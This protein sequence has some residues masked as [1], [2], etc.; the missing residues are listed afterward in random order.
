MTKEMGKNKNL[1]IYHVPNHMGKI[2]AIASREMSKGNEICFVAFNNTKGDLQKE[3]II[4]KIPEDYVDEKEHRKFDENARRFLECVANKKIDRERD[5]KEFVRYDNTSLWWFV[6]FNFYRHHVRNVVYYI[7]VL[8]RMINKEKPNN[9][10]IINDKSVLAKTV[11]RMGETNDISIQLISPNAFLRLNLLLKSSF[12]KI[13]PYV[14]LH[15]IN[16]RSFIRKNW[17]KL[18]PSTNPRNKDEN[19][20]VNKILFASMGRGKEVVDPVTGKVKV[21]DVHVESLMSELKKG[22]EN[23]ILFLYTPPTISFGLRKLYKRIMQDNG[24]IIMPWEYYLDKRINKIISNEARGLKRKWRELKNNHSF[25]QSLIYKSI[26]LWEILKD[27]FRFMFLFQFPCS[28]KFIELSKKII[29]TEKIN[30]IVLACENCPPINRAF[31]V[32]GNLKGIPIWAIQHG[33]ILPYFDESIADYGWTTDELRCNSSKYSVLPSKICVYGDYTK[34]TL[35]ELG[36]PQDRIVVTGQPRYDL[37]INAVY[38]KEKIIKELGLD[39]NRKVVLLMTQAFPQIEKRE[40]LFNTVAKAAEKLDQEQ[41]VVKPHPSESKKWYQDR[42]K[43]FNANI[44]ILSEKFDTYKAIYI[45]DVILAMFS[46]TIIEARILDTPV[47]LV[48]I[49]KKEVIT[50]YAKNSVASAYKDDLVPAI[51]NALYN[52]EVHKELAKARKKFVYE[53]AYKQDGK[54]SKRVA[55]LITQMIEESEKRKK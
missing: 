26:N 13:N 10:I 1:V 50:P 6:N 7:E 14:A 43:R 28:I 35:I 47:I 5:F 2:E 31:T 53:H 32:A 8:G 55:D 51:K 9:I 37:L 30:I 52:E 40:L 36:Y 23:N 22:D 48:N 16:L 41:L 44:K 46:T 33:I 27:E 39:P 25:K 17:M 42:V 19:R 24:I 29:D 20:K 18:I 38:D 34:N 49:T 21:E 3:K 45:A 11:V 12:T 54:A 15:F 4:C